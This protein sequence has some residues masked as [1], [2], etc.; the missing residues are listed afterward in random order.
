M[1]SRARETTKDI[2]GQ[3]FTAYK[4]QG[5]V[6][7]SVRHEKAKTISIILVTYINLT[8]QCSSWSILRKTL[9]DLGC[10]VFLL[11]QKPYPGRIKLCKIRFARIVKNGLK[12][13]FFDQFILK[14]G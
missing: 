12:V 4:Y 14:G 13:Y 9:E 10:P 11:Q 1:L 6:T 7:L 5:T 2:T 8:G 3:R